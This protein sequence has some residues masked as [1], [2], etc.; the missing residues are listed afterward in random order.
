ML[1]SQHKE[2]IEVFSP[3]PGGNELFRVDDALLNRRPGKGIWRWQEDDWALWTDADPTH[4]EDLGALIPG[5][6]PGSAL[7][8]GAGQGVFLIT[9]DGQMAP[10]SEAVTRATPGAVFYCGIKLRD[11]RFVLGTVD[12]GIFLVSADGTTV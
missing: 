11:G 3:G 4:S 7:F 12:R 9:P 1:C 8:A 2:K 5:P 10:W 6:T